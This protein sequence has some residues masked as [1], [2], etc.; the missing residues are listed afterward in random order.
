[1][2]KCGLINRKRLLEVKNFEE[3]EKHMMVP[4][5]LIRKSRILFANVGAVASVVTSSALQLPLEYSVPF[6]IISSGVAW[7]LGFIIDP[8]IVCTNPYKKNKE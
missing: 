7:A 2:S 3:Q 1:M 8:Y 4:L 5:C 6:I